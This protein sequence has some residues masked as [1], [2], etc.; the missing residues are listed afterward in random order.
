MKKWPLEW[1]FRCRADWN[2][3]NFR[4]KHL[5][6]IS[7]F[8]WLFH[9]LETTPSSESLIFSR[10]FTSK[11]Q[12]NLVNHSFNLVNCQAKKALQ[13]IWYVAKTIP[14]TPLT[15]LLSHQRG[16]RCHGC[17]QRKIEKSASVWIA[18]GFAGLPTRGLIGTKKWQPSRPARMDNGR[19]A[20][21]WF[22]FYR[23]RH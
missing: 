5:P 1:L 7:S 13:P 4:T 8:F 14:M 3:I 20:C 23:K 11:T 15:Q 12:T 2:S 21:V 18:I 6:G 19:Q 10:P 16:G 17:L 22:S 9:S